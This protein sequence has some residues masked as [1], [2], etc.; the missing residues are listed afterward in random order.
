MKHL[1]YIANGLG[2]W[3]SVYAFDWVLSKFCTHVLPHLKSDFSFY[4]ASIL[5]AI[6]S[7]HI[8]GWIFTK[9]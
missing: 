4:G 8:V 2:V 7:F 6:I 5:V 3:L 1:K 9:D